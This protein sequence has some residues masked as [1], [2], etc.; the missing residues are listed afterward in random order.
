MFAVL[1]GLGVAVA[2]MARTLGAMAWTLGAISRAVI[3][4][5]DGQFARCGF[6]DRGEWDQ[7]GQSHRGGKNQIFH[8]SS[9]VNICTTRTDHCGN[10]FREVDN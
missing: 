5:L 8:E 4:D 3:D 6:C 1:D 2:A 10:W 9:S 7:R